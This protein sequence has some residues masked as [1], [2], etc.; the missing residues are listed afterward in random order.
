MDSLPLS[1]GIPPSRALGLNQLTIDRN[2]LLLSAKTAL[3]AW[4]VYFFFSCVYNR[5]FHPLRH[6]PGPFW[7]SVTNLWKLYICITKKVHTKGI[8]YHKKHG[9]LRHNRI[10]IK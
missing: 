2:L 1:M 8:E 7:A 10:L 3:L 5:Y 4:A 9:M 6:F